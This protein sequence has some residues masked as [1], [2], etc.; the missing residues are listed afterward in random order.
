MTSYDVKS[1]DKSSLAV[2]INTTQTTGIKISAMTIN[3]TTTAWANQ[4]GGVVEVTEEIDGVFKREYIYYTGGTENSDS[5]F[6]LSGVVRGVTRDTSDPT[7]GGTGQ[8]FNKGATVRMSNFHY[9]FNQKADVDRANTFTEHQ[10]IDTN[11]EMRFS[12]SNEAI[13][14]DGGELYLKSTTTSAQ[15]LADL[16][17]LSGSDEKVKISSNDTTEDYLINKIVGGDGV[18]T[19]ETGDG[20]DEDITLAVDLATDPGLEMSSNQLRVKIKTDG[21]VTRDSDG[22][23]VSFPLPTGGMMIWTTDTAPTGWLLC[24]GQAVSRTTY[25]AL[26]A[27]VSTTFGVGDGSTTFNLPDLRGRFPLGQDDMGGAS[28]DRVTDTE[29]DTVGSSAGN[30]DADHSHTIDPNNETIDRS[31]GGGSSYGYDDSGTQPTS[32]DSA[33]PPYITLNYI[34]KT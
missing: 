26:F 33:M 2:K 31:G 17:A 29:A 18:S 32:T 8:S 3:E 4:S 1:G 12:D 19:T 22:L 20:G 30:N 7:S 25:S 14:S 6:T 13:Y 27:V 5:S 23:S 11:K 28:A 9:L 10:T 24:Y 34:I 16:A 21:G 15:P